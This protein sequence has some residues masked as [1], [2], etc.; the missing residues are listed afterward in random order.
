MPV[1][2]SALTV[3][4]E[5]EVL[6]WER[7]DLFCATQAI[8]DK[9]S[10][11]TSKNV[12]S[13]GSELARLTVLEADFKDVNQRIRQTNVLADSKSRLDTTKVNSSFFELVDTTKNNYYKVSKRSEVLEPSS[14]KSSGAPGV[15]RLPRLDLPTFSGKIEEWPEFSS[16]YQSLVGSD[17]SLDDTSKFQYLRTC[18]KGDAL[19]V[20]SGFTLEAKNYSLAWEALKSRYQNPRR[21][22]SIYVNKILNFSPLSDNSLS[23]LE[24]F[25]AAHETSINALNALSLPD[26]GDFIKLQIA[27]NNLD[28]GTRKAFEEGHSSSE[29]PS[30]KSLIE[31]VTERCRIAELISGDKKG[32]A[33]RPQKSGFSGQFKVA[34]VSSTPVSPTPSKGK[35]NQECTHTSDPKP[36]STGQNSSDSPVKGESA[37]NN[38]KCWNCGGPHTFRKCKVTL[39]K[40][41]YRCGRPEVTTMDCPKC[42]SLNRKGGQRRGSL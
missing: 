40:F 4:Q 23:S 29:I 41:C 12:D 38:P 42:C 30:Y 3:E 7:Q 31:F 25:L 18:L 21:L 27:L 15:C 37:P 36:V 35:V 13:F 26:V 11:L 16:L 28:S 34:S 1:S 33:C 20:I 17:H 14:Q 2:D 19:A 39:K 32:Q 10:K 22:A 24:R 9:S 8:F 6:Q 5:L